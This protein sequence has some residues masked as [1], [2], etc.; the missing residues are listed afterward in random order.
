MGKKER[1]DAR[2]EVYSK[3]N[4]SFEIMKSILG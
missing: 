1:D 2:K 3:H 4:S